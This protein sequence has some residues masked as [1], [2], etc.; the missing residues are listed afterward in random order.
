M[1]STFADEHEGLEKESAQEEKPQKSTFVDNPDDAPDIEASEADLHEADEEPEERPKR[2]SKREEAPSYDPVA[3]HAQLSSFAEEA[4]RAEVQN[5]LGRIN[6]ELKQLPRPPR[7]EEELLSLTEQQ[8]WA[9]QQAET[10][11]Q[12]LIHYRDN[13]LP[14]AASLKVAEKKQMASQIVGLQNSLQ[15]TNPER[16][17]KVVSRAYDLVNDPRSGVGAT[18]LANPSFYQLLDLTI[19]GEELKQKESRKKL[20]LMSDRASV[21]GRGGAANPIEASPLPPDA[22]KRLRSM[23]LSD[24]QVKRTLSRRRA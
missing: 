19:A 4:A 18:E 5:E 16:W 14:Q 8:K 10:R 7:S 13:I 22:A 1:A 6:A 11:R 15:Q 12:N 24:D 23:G 20:R 3:A 17:H 21:A 2:R 9:L